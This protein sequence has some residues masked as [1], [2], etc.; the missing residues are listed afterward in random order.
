MSMCWPRPERSRSTIA[1]S[2][3]IVVNSAAVMSPMLTPGRT[4]PPPS[5]PVMLSMPPIACTI[6]SSAARFANGPSCPKPDTDAMMSL[7]LR[8]LSVA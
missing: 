8:V 3:P 2:T 7:G 5:S 1:D 6:T 4:G